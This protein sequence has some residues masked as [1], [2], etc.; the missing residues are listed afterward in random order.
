MEQ[1]PNQTLRHCVVFAHPN[2]TS[3]CGEI[4]R[5]YTDEVASEGQE[6]VVR[7]LYDMGFNPV[8]GDQ[9][10]PGQGGELAPDVGTELSFIEESDALVL[11]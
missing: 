5:T 1:A 10:R 2:R 11:G 9:E 7:D 3:F 6:V 8:L 4:L